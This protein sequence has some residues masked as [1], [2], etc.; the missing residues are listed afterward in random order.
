MACGESR[1]VAFRCSVFSGLGHLRTSEVGELR[2]RT[3]R[4]I[5]EHLARHRLLREDRHDD[6]HHAAEAGLAASAV[7]ASSGPK[8]LQWGW[9]GGLTGVRAAERVDRDDRGML[10]PSD[11]PPLRDQRVARAGLGSRRESLDRDV[12]PERSVPGQPHFTHA[13]ASGD[14][15][16]FGDE[17]QAHHVIPSLGLITPEW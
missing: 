12:A 1:I 8:W 17:T 3:V 6:R 5:G 4:R 14:L 16:N 2:E 9:S 15:R 13:A 7:C 10:D 11:D